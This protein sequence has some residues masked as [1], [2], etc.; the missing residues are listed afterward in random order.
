MKRVINTLFRRTQRE[1]EYQTLDNLIQPSKVLFRAKSTFWFDLFPDEIVID[2]NKIIIIHR[3]FF[4]SHTVTSIPLYNLT[5]VTCSVNL[6]FGSVQFEIFGDMNQPEPVRYLSRNDAL[7][8]EK[9]I[10]GLVICYRQKVDLS[11]Y[12]TQNIVGKLLELGKV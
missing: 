7:R 8:V 11:S 4:S 9:I 2:L 5:N 6:L 3:I 12:D 1:Q 10:N